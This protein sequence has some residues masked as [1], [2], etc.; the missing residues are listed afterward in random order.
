[1]SSVTCGWILHPLP[2]FNVVDFSNTTNSSDDIDQIVAD[3]MM[4]RRNDEQTLRARLL[5]CIMRNRAR[6]ATI[7]RGLLCGPLDGRCHSH[8]SEPALHELH[9]LA[10]VSGGS[11]IGCWFQYE[12]AQTWRC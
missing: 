10:Q 3:S 7:T 4:L 8:D 5:E 1:M 11:S 9:V 6:C 12:V 2:T